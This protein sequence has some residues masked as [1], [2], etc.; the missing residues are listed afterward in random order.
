MSK[1]FMTLLTEAEEA[2]AQPEEDKVIPAS[3][4]NTLVRRYV[5]MLTKPNGGGVRPKIDGTIDFER[6]YNAYMNEEDGA[7]VQWRYLLKNGLGITDMKF[8]NVKDKSPNKIKDLYLIPTVVGFANTLKTMASESPQ[9]MNMPIKNEILATIEFLLSKMDQAAIS[10]VIPQINEVF[11]QIDADNK[12]EGMNVN[13]A[14]NINGIQKQLQRMLD[15]KK[16]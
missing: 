14:K 2:M 16:V 5:M 8:I 1:K 7:D 10:K 4:L 11:A 6:I 9:K 3:P 12:E 13:I 15:Q